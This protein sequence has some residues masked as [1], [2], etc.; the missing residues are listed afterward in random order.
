MG[1]DETRHVSLPQ[2]AGTRLV[3]GVQRAFRKRC[4]YCG[5]GSVFQSWFTLSDRCPSC[6][7]LYAYEDGYFLGA[8]VIN[9]VVTELLTVAVV[10]W[11]I[12]G[13]DLDVLPMQLTGISLAVL[14]PLLLYPTALLIWVAIDNTF[15]PPDAHPDQRRP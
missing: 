1:S 7:T 6:Q 5:G 14:L 8:Y 10:I 3:A 11:L 12:A 9:L 15:H 2:S 4:P 13:T